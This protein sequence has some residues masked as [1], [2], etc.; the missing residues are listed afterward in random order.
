MNDTKRWIPV[1]EGLWSDPSADGGEAQLIG[2]HCLTCGEL[3][4]PRQ[5][6]GL[7]S[8]CQSK[9][10]EDI[11]LSSKGKIYSYTVV[12]QRPP[13]YYKAEVPYAIGFVELPEGIRVETLFT[14][15][16]L[17]KL[18]V[19]MDVEM[20]IEK[21]HEDDEGNEIVAYKFRPVTS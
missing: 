8:Y 17:E 20:V 19:G 10:L 16:D 21:L 12:M 13:V 14:G 18:H 1:R 3:F 7:C 15:C 2:S 9:D 11:R 6:S 5:D 4:F